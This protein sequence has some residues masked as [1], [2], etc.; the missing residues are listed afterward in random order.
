MLIRNFRALADT[1]EKQGYAIPK[2]LIVDIGSND[3]TLLQGFKE[4]G[5]K[6]VG[7]EP[8]GARMWQKERHYDDQKFFQ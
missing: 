6:V 4:K 3:G 1:L 2:S 8:T 5:M 7:V